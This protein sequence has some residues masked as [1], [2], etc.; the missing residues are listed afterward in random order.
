MAIEDYSNFSCLYSNYANS[1]T[2]KSNL[3][4]IS[5]LA[6]SFFSREANYPYP[7]K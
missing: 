7:R 1:W 4:L 2:G 6:K 5:F 3:E